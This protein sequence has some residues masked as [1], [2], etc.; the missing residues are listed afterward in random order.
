[1]SYLKHSLCCHLISHA[2]VIKRIAKYESYE[3]HYCIIS[4]LEF[5]DS[6]IM[7]ITCRSKSEESILAQS[8]LLL[9]NWCMHIF[10]HYINVRNGKNVITNGISKF[11]SN[12]KYM[13]IRW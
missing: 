12:G 11:G 6:T 5:L 10:S 3:N 13:L 2:A 4:L 8:M 9:L 7:G 1:M